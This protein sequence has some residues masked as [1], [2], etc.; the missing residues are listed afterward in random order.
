VCG[1]APHTGRIMRP[2][3]EGGRERDFDM[4]RTAI[5]YFSR[6]GQNYWDGKIVDLA[7][8][9]TELA[10]ETIKNAVSGDLFEVKTVK[11]YAADYKACAAQ[12]SGELRR[13]ERVA[14]KAYKDDLGK[15]DI[16]FVGYPNW[17][18]TMPM[19]MWT[20][21]EH[22]DLAGKKIAPFCT[23]EGSGM[24]A[25]EKDLRDICRGAQLFPGLPVRG[26]RVK[27][28][29]DIIAEWAKKATA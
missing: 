14:V 3:A 5:V 19:A 11:P 15:Y 22:Y 7:R 1:A 23:N 6:R 8:G 4:S 10:A 21:L 18:G 29:A 25:S 16:I 28:S 17:C 24:G 12:A 2:G 26:C 13:K 27:E 20:F 9:N